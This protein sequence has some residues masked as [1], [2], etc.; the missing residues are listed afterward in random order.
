MLFN[1]ITR[2]F[3]NQSFADVNSY[4]YSRLRRTNGIVFSNHKREG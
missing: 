2:E 1:F 4:N 3:D